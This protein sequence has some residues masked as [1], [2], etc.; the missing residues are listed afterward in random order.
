MRVLIA[1]DHAVLREGLSVLVDA[2]ADMEVVG[3][4]A[5]GAEAVEAALRLKPDVVVMDLTMPRRGGV[6]AIQEIRAQAPAVKVLVLTMHDDPSYLRAAIAAGGG[7]YLVKS[8]AGAELVEAI[9]RVGAGETYLN[10]SV[11]AQR[12]HELM[13]EVNQT[14]DRSGHKVPASRLSRREREV[15]DLVAHGYTN[16]EIAERLGVGKKSVDT[17]RLRLSEKLGLRTRADLVRYALEVGILAPDSE[18]RRDKP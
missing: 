13:R 11:E 12:A 16:R 8:A 2:E 1:D 3:E 9:R 14:R 15:L 10:L 18:S 5:D 4:A 6:D 17:Y 7:G